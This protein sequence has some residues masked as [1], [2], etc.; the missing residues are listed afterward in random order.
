MVSHLVMLNS[1]YGVNA[2]WP[3]RSALENPQKPGEFDR[4]N[5]A[6]REVTADGL[7]A[8]W[9]RAIPLPDKNQW[10]DPA[11]VKAHQCI[12]LESDPTSSSRQ[13]PSVRLPG[14]FRLEAYN[15]SKG[16]QYWDGADIRVPTL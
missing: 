11:V 12:T 1:L 15:L 10:R 14:G 5:T 4:R 7:I 8:N 9:T 2:P 3:Y 6:Y 13:P 16:Q